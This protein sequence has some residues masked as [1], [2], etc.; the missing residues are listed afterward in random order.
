MAP[1]RFY[2]GPDMTL[3]VMWANRLYKLIEAYT[4]HCVKQDGG[5]GSDYTDENIDEVRAAMDETMLWVNT[6]IQRIIEKT[7]H[8]PIVGDK[9]WEP[10]S[11]RGGEVQIVERTFYTPFREPSILGVV[12]HLDMNQY[13]YLAEYVE[14]TNEE[15]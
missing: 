8:L 6:F 10:N 15:S 7:G 9:L 1:E 11:S 4:T 13:D 12:Y 5:H 14:G 3:E 2:L